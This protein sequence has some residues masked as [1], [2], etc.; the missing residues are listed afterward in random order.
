M[1]PR[2]EAVAFDCF[3][4]LID[5]GD[6]A[7][8]EAY[9]VICREQGIPVDG[10]AFYNRWM[11]IWRRLAESGSSADGGSIGVATAAETN[12]NEPG[13]LSEAEA[14]PPHPEH[15]TPSAG[16]SRSLNGPT[17]PYRPYREEWP[18]HFALCFEELGVK[19]DPQR[20]HDR[21]VELIAG[22]RAFPESRRA[23]ETVSR[24]LPVALMSNADDDFLMPCLARNA[25][26]F[27]VVVSSETAR[28][29]KPHEAIFVALHEAIG[30][31]KENIL[32]VG[33]SR[34]ADIVGAKHA[35]LQAAWVDR[36]R[37]SRSLDRS[38]IGGPLDD[39]LDQY[40]P[41][42]EITSLDEVIEI[43]RG[44]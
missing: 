2:I 20:A 14:I 7:F 34:F 5:Y 37:S 42:Y 10:P 6:E 39:I 1:R 27:P 33:D 43:I 15:H 32:Y 3:G 44:A 25:L 4:T 9:G 18:E 26:T 17:I 24:R 38:S 35:G 40:K 13:P 29:Y 16:R 28:A 23:V 12:E 31:A 41:D 11:A 21:L 36:K 19:G 8:A 30:V 22:G